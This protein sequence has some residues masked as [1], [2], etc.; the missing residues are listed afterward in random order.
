MLF[1]GLTVGIGLLA[2]VV[3]PV[4]FLRSTGIGGFLIPLISVAVALTLLPVLLATVGPVARLAPA[5]QRE[6]APARGWTAWAAFTVRHRGP[7][8]IAGTRRRWPC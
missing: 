6:L 5:A 3:L 7:A 1:S 4:P 8:A 2:L